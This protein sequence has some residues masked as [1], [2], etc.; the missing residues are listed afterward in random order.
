MEHP[1][2]FSPYLSRRS[3]VVGFYAVLDAAMRS[4]SKS[5]AGQDL[6][7]ILACN[8]TNPSRSVKI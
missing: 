1:A 4:R 5:S 6:W 7:S 2:L 8:V 3:K